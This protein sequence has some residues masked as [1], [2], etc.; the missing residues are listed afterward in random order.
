MNV[1][2]PISDYALIGNCRTAALISSDGSIDWL[3]MPR[4]DAPSVFGALLDTRKGGNWI[5]RPSHIRGSTRRYVDDSNVLETDHETPTGIVRVTDLMT[6]R[7]EEA[8]HESL[9]P[10][11]EVLRRVECLDGSSDLFMRFEPRP[12]YAAGKSIIRHREATGYVC[13]LHRDTYVFR[14]DRPCDISDDG[15]SLASMFTLR[16]GE[17]AYFSLVFAGTEPLVLVPLN[18]MADR[19]IDQS[20]KWW[21]S[22]AARC[23]YDGPFRESVV[24]SALVL[25]LMAYAPSGAIIAAPTTSLP[26]WP[27]GVKNWD[28]R[29][30]WLRDASFTMRALIGIGYEQEAGAFLEWLLHATWKTQPKLRVVY[31]VHGELLGRE[32]VLDTLEGY[33]QSRPV[34]IGNQA[35]TQMQLDI[36]GEI[37]TAV[38]E[39]LSHGKTID[40]TEAKVLANIG[41]YVCRR[42]EDADAGIWEKRDDLAHRTYS[43]GMCWVALDRLL[44]L[45]RDGWVKVDERKL[46]ETMSAIRDS[47]ERRGYHTGLQSYVEELDGDEVDASLLLMGISGYADPASPRMQSTLR[48]IRKQLEKKG[49]IYRMRIGGDTLPPGEGAFSL[50]TLW[51]IQLLA[52]SGQTKE[53]NTWFQDFLARG[54]D[55]G[56][57]SEEI[58]PD[59]GDALGNFPQAFTH[60]G[61]INTALML[62]S[63]AGPTM[64]GRNDI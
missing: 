60:I 34:R 54:N 29:Y 15:S 40:R 42:W 44:K 30:C 59:T 39:Y 13:S 12:E 51:A 9:T 14:T 20:V 28:Y 11:H 26:E 3:C 17:S 45:A 25:K 63:A 16:K 7:D 19:R 57:F 21:R 50:C 6:V 64:N 1:Y 27:G 4:F 31:D 22:W 62:E 41:D 43:R 49:L 38:A 53:A 56:L 23:R 35:S 48:Q 61:I 18:A 8:K 2:R 33:R 36:Y 32:R 52:L 37:I 46:A 58:D 5:L 10:Y 47:I 24:R 55:V